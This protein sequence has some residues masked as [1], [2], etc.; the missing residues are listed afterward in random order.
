MKR[1]H[2]LSAFISKLLNPVNSNAIVLRCPFCGRRLIAVDS[3]TDVSPQNTK[4]PLS[5]PHAPDD[6]ELL[7]DEKHRKIEGEVVQKP[8]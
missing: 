7:K 4:G 6:E 3:A 8:W 2:A 5:I 1:K